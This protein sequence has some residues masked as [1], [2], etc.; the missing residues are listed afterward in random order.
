M[1]GLKKGGL[2]MKPT[3]PFNRRSFFTL[4][5][6]GV[7]TTSVAIVFGP[8][9]AM[10]CSDQD[11]G[12]NANPSGQ[13]QNCNQSSGRPVRT[14]CNDPIS[15]TPDADPPEWGRRCTPRPVNRPCTDNDRPPIFV[16]G[17]GRGKSC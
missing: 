5:A 12:P 13:G 11:R 2:S 16:D 8:A 7:A 3:R 15:A 10:G 4:V 1:P 17:V 6:G 14:G 9:H